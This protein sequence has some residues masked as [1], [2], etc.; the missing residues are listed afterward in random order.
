MFLVMA[1]GLRVSVQS[2][3]DLTP[4][5]LGTKVM[6]DEICDWFNKQAE[7]ASEDSDF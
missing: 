5:L 2:E 7:N 3:E 1:A 4:L 6:T